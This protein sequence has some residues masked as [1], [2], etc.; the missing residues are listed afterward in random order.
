M[1][2]TEMERM[3]ETFG[4]TLTNSDDEIVVDLYY[5]EKGACRFDIWQWFD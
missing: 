5:W 4:D 1:T 3:W 2:I